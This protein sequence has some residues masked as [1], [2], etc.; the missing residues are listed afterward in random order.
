MNKTAKPYFDNQGDPTLIESAIVVADILG[1][2]NIVGDAFDGNK[3]QEVLDFFYK[4]VNNAYLNVRDPSQVKWCVKVFSDNLIVAYPF[5]GRSNGYF[6][7]Y[8][9]CYSIGQFQLELARN[10]IFIRGGISL[11]QAHVN[12]LL[13]F[14]STFSE[15]KAAEKQANVPRVVLLESAT[16]YLNDNPEVGENLVLKPIIGDDSGIKFINYMYPLGT[17]DDMKQKEIVKSH[18][19]YVESNLNKFKPDRN[20][21]GCGIYNKYVWVAGYHNAFCR[22]SK[23]YTEE[24]YL[25]SD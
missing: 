12:D 13:V 6:E 10:G 1:Y 8:Q 19:K 2:E 22:S 18:K 25:I 7:F 11:G 4:H 17:K 9:A 14:T 5:I 20:Q 15:L 16:K 21:E 3:Q 24:E 23:Y